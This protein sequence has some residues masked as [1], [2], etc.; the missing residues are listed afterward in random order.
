MTPTLSD[1]AADTVTLLP[2]TVVPPAGDVNET[3]GALLSTITVT[4][5]AV[6]VFPAAS[7][8]TAVRVWL[9]FVALV[10][11]HTTLYG[12]V[13]ASVPSGAPSSMNCTPATPTLS[14][15]VADSVTAAPVTVVPVAGAVNEIVGALLSTVT[16]TEPAAVVCPTAS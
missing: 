14:D 8:A 12:A 7:R 4:A 9:A 11:F 5:V 2:V 13:V 10:V 16:V 15:A 1:A 6:A 3:V